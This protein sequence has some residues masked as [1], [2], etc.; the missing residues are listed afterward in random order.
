MGRTAT[1][2][3][4]SVIVFGVIFFWSDLAHTFVDSEGELVRFIES[5][6]ERKAP[7]RLS[8]ITA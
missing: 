8:K 1:Y 5:I 3:F 4:P 7:I 6:A 2:R